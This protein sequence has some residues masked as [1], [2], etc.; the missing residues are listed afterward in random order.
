MDIVKRRLAL[1]AALLCLVG[2]A[3]TLPR[4]LDSARL[5]AAQ[6][7]PVRLAELGLDRRFDA[8]VAYREI[9]SALGAGDVELAQSFVAL[10]DERRVAV[11]SHLRVR[12]SAARARE[13]SV[14]NVVIRFGEGF[15]TGE[16]EDLAQLAGTL[17]GDLFVFGDLRDVAREGMRA[18]RGEE[19]NELILGLSCLGLAITAGTYATFGAGSPARLGLSILKA[20]GRTGRMTAEMS[21][22]VFRPLYRVFDRPA[23]Q[24][25]LG[26]QALWHPGAVMRAAR[27]SVKV[28]RAQALFDVL[29][30]VG[31]IQAKAGTRTA[32][33]GLRIGEG[34]KDMARLTALASSKGSKTRAVLKL[35]GRGAIALTVGLWEL[36]SWLFWAA[37]LLLGWCAS[38]KLLT[39][40]A[41]LRFFQWRKQA[42]AVLAAG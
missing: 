4:A 35:L 26:S 3:A 25:A 14:L 11:E 37:V 15:F 28:E 33:E 18:A 7:D 38:L 20:A 19:V 39:E 34:P 1:A 5:L 29:S 12:V 31:R 9:E 13:T 36:T 32:L 30:D 24:T 8:A 2:S 22:A 17:S 21:A 16:P 23:L 42:R 41:A 6:D 10:A 27:E 40:R